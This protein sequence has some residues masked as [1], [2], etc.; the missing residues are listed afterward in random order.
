MRGVMKTKGQHWRH[1]V[2]CLQHLQV[3][4]L[5]TNPPGFNIYKEPLSS[6]QCRAAHSILLSAPV[7]TGCG[8]HSDTIPLL[9]H[10]GRTGPLRGIKDD[11]SAR[12]E[13]IDA[14]LHI[15]SVRC[16]AASHRIYRDL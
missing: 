6:D 3:R 8:V 13:R 4:V 11:C 2:A 9:A 15:S 1:R 16:A 5:L 10:S 7:Q 14:A 12:I